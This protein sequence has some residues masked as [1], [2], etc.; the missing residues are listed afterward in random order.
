MDRLVWFIGF[1]WSFAFRWPISIQSLFLR[2]CTLDQ[3]THV[4]ITSRAKQI[5][6]EEAKMGETFLSYAIMPFTCIMHLIFSYPYTPP[7]FDVTFCEV[8]VDS[9]T[10]TRCLYHQMCRYVFNEHSASYESGSMNV[11]STFGDFLGQAKGLSSEEA[12]RRL[13]V[14]GHNMIPMAKPTVLGN[15]GKEFAKAFYL[16]QNFMVWTWAPYWYYYMAVVQT[17]VRVMGGIIVG[18]FQYLSDSVLY[19]ISNVEGFVK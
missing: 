8:S 18:V 2:R 19:Q 14:V 15:I 9:M 17:I 16:Y 11:G 12:E 13:H 6:V 5:E 10:G 1:L 3:A 4:A 7:G